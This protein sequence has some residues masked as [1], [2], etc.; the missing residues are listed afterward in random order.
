MIHELARVDDGV[1]IGDGTKVWANAHICKGAIIGEDVVIG[2]NVYIGPNVI[3]GDKCKI[4]NNSLIYEGVTM[5]NGV[6]IGPN[7]VT[8]NDILPR[9]VGEWKHRFRTTLFKKGCS[10]GANSTIV[11][12]ITIGENSGVGS[13]SV[14]TKDVEAGMLVLGNPARS[15]GTVTERRLKYNDL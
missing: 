11:C 2:E 1:V 12:G 13:G 4:Q 5:E 14:V 3:I 10:I 7:V 8:T 9:A 15:V 6:F